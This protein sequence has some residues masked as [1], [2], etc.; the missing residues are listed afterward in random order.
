MNKAG[1]IGGRNT[2]TGSGNKKMDHEKTVRRQRRIAMLALAAASVPMVV[3]VPRALAQDD[4]YT[5]PDNGNWSTPANWS[6][7]HVPAYEDNANLNFPSD[8]SADPMQ[9]NF[10]YAYGTTA[11]IASLK[12]PVQ[13]TLSQTTAGT[14]MV[15]GEEDVG[16][17][18]FYSV[19]YLQ[20]A[21]TNTTFGLN[22]D[23]DYDL[24]GSGI[25]S[26]GG[27]E[28]IGKSSQ[29]DFSQS[30]GS[31]TITGNLYI[32]AL[33][34]ASSYYDLSGSNG[35]FEYLAANAEQFGVVETLTQQSGASYAIGPGGGFSQENG[36]NTITGEASNGFSFQVWHNSSYNLSGGTLVLPSV[37]GAAVNNGLFTLGGSGVLTGYIQNA[38]TLGTNSEG[39]NDSGFFMSGGVIDQNA[40][41]ENDAGAAMSG[42]T[43]L[44]TLIN[45]SGFTQTG[46]TVQGLVRNSGTYYVSGG[47]FSAAGFAGG[48]Q[49][50]IGGTFSLQAGGTINMGSSTFIN[51]GNFYYVG[52][53]FNGSLLNQGIAAFYG[54]GLAISNGAENDQTMSIGV[55]NGLTNVTFGASGLDN[56]GQ[57]TF[58]D[59]N[60]I[61]SVVNESGAELVSSSYDPVGTITGTLINQGLFEPGNVTVT[62]AITNSGTTQLGNNGT[63]ADILKATSGLTNT[64]IVQFTGGKLT[65][66]S[67]VNNPGGLIEFQAGLTGIYSLSQVV[68]NAGGVITV[69]TSTQ[70]TFANF[71]GGNTAGGDIQIQNGASFTSTTAFGNSGTIELQGS[72]AALNGG[73]LSN[74]GSITGLG[75]ISNTLVNLGIVEASGGK[76]VISSSNFSNSNKLETGQIIVDAAATIQFTQGLASNGGTITNTGGTFDNNNQPLTNMN[77]AVINGNGTF[78]TGGTGLTNSTGALIDVTAGTSFYGPVI[79]SGAIQIYGS[80]TTFYGNVTENT[81]GTIK[82]T[83]GSVYFLAN[84]SIAGLYTSDPSDNYFTGLTINPGGAMSGGSGDRFFL[85][86]L[87][88]LANNGTFNSSGTLSAGA[89][90]NTGTFIQTGT[91]IETGHFINSGNLVLGGTQNWSQGSS[92]TSTGGT[93]TIVNDAGANGSSPP[94]AVTSGTTTFAST[95]HL[96]GLSVGV[97]GTVQIIGGGTGHRS[98]VFTP[99]ISVS[100]KLDLT[101]NDL[102]IQAAGPAGLAAASTLAADGYANGTWTGNGINSSA[103]A[104]D[105][106]HLTAVG[107]IQND[108]SGTALYTSIHPFD[109]VVPGANDVLVKYTY[110]GDADLNGEVDGTDYTRIDNGYLGHATGWFNGD[111]NYDGVVNGSDYTL[112][113]NAFNTQG[114]QEDIE[115]A[116]VTAQVGSATS[117]PEPSS[118]LVVALA[119]LSLLR[120][121]RLVGA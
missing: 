101:T 116:S 14:A 110:Y 74:V 83:A 9:V 31:N 115:V 3:F 67:L 43:I 84:A 118:G 111:F 63:T 16:G 105:N 53:T 48:P 34:N 72:T 78:R 99:S 11:G 100:G 35:P 58:G 24:A 47:T 86:A 44:G 55:Y 17:I 70:V 62:G 56:L 119:G 89:V 59:A 121:R 46:G 20:T 66:G 50:Q 19:T 32:G 30:G 45:N 107:V 1:Y 76:L 104:A 57:V 37:A 40:T 75:R 54:I 42:G 87:T 91:L 120:R 49:N 73:L 13:V 12:M 95:Q 96:A 113:D 98:V 114:A 28:F 29:G 112:I 61:G 97:G 18:N 82:V 71:S 21:G 85:S 26:V 25:L 6:L 93:V 68:S 103:A 64:G 81:G 15:A 38:A 117:V 27:D 88:T 80:T 5:G 77:G 106:T 2:F 7:G 109:G 52:G 36:T 90:V 79:N 23:A 102:D 60:I 4:N 94:V 33:G 8:T 69:G 10:D 92:F 51:Q 65:G 41:L 22:L 108:Q 39:E